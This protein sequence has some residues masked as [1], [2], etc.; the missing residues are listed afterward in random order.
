MGNELILSVVS[1]YSDDC[2]IP[3]YGY[4]IS[5]CAG[6]FEAGKEYRAVIFSRIYKLGDGM[7][8]DRSI[9]VYNGSEDGYGDPDG[10]CYTSLTEFNAEWETVE[11]RRS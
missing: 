6:A 8:E 3:T 10:R 9:T 7:T 1:R 11:V 2:F 5:D 4:K